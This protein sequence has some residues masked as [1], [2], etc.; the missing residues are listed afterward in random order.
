MQ[1]SKRAQLAIFLTVVVDLL[2]FGIVIPIMPLYARNLALHPSPWM[3]WV[4]STLNLQDPFAIW[5]GVVLAL[6]LVAIACGA[7]A[8]VAPALGALAVLRVGGHDALHQ[9][10]AHDVALVERH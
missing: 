6:S 3:S 9:L 8:G 7:A 1:P 4:N 2:G 10:V 5:A